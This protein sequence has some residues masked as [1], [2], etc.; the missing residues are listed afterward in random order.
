MNV[1]IVHDVGVGERK[2]FEQVINKLNISQGLIEDSSNSNKDFPLTIFGDFL[3]NF[4]F[5]FELSLLVFVH[6]CGRFLVF[7]IDHHH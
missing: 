5:L 1:L 4:D 2:E 7:E 6:L 3:D